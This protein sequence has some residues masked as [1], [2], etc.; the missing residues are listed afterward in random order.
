MP[1]RR[2][3]EASVIPSVNGVL[4]HKRHEETCT[5]EA[6]ES[7]CV[8]PES[9]YETCKL[10]VYDVGCVYGGNT[11]AQSACMYSLSLLHT[12]VHFLHIEN[13]GLSSPTHMDVRA[14]HS[15]AL[16]LFS[17]LPILLLSSSTG[18]ECAQ[19]HLECEH[20]RSEVFCNAL[21]DN[22]TRACTD[23]IVNVCRSAFL[24]SGCT[25]CTN[26]LV[27]CQGES[28]REHSCAAVS[29]C[30]EALENEPENCDETAEASC[31]YS[32]AASN[33]S[34]RFC[35]S[36]EDESAIWD[37]EL[38]CASTQYHARLSLSLSLSLCVSLCM[39]T[40]I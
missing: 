13:Q 14:I 37:K 11:H 33:F 26:A 19:N 35:E 25:E 18:V 21:S 31:V 16:V 12:S 38:M 29:V 34:E 10:A 8:H 23:A 9:E 36:K 39:F 5:V 7:E 6:V 1:I 3:I 15:L 2:D 28:V 27:A 20:E 17:S 24:L 22:R 30:I 32:L 40:H 4:G